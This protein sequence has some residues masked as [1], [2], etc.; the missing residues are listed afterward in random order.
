MIFKVIG[1]KKQNKKFYKLI[2]LNVI[3]SRK[4][5]THSEIKFFSL[6]ILSHYL[7]F[8]HNR[9]LCH[10]GAFITLLLAFFLSFVLLPPVHWLN[11][12][13]LSRPLAVPLVFFSFLGGLGALIIKSLPFLSNQ[14]R[15]LQE[16]FLPTL[17][18]SLF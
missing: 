12:W 5:K 6:G 1:S 17:N 13:G 9:S 7:F 4:K 2:P 8:P 14:F 3:L 15:G 10:Q 11:R 18:K 16:E